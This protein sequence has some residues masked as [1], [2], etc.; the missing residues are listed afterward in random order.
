MNL[1]WVQ[2]WT[3]TVLGSKND[4]IL[5]SLQSYMSSKNDNET[6]FIYNRVSSEE[7]LQSYE[8]GQ[9]SKVYTIMQ[10]CNLG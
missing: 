6:D 5:A 9:N 1:K 7:I 4:I 3:L 10:K 2:S 8:I